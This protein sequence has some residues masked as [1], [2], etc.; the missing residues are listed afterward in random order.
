MS[1]TRSRALQA[2]LLGL[3]IAIRFAMRN[4]LRPDNTT[5]VIRENLVV[6]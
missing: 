5:D 2:D 6:I 1:P 3:P 4:A